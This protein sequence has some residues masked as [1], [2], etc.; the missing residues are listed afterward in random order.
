MLNFVAD[1]HPKKPWPARE[2]GAYLRWIRAMSSPLY[3][4]L[5]Y[6]EVF[7]LQINYYKEEESHCY[8][9]EHH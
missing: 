1:C 6:L 8:A 2:R 7:E 5:V 9:H 4:A 3:K